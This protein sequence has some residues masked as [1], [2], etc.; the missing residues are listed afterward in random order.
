MN[1]RNHACWWALVALLTLI[2]ATASM[3]N[4]TDVKIVRSHT[5]P[6]GVS[7]AGIYTL[8]GSLS[9]HSAGNPISGGVYTLK[10]GLW[11]E[12]A[13]IQSEIYLPII[14]R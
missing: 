5:G 13:L 9:Q 12:G 3:I 11:S 7:S 6:G 2:L 10:G 14:F 8:S 1:T 4:L